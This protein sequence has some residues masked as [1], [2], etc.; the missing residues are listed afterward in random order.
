MMRYRVNPNINVIKSLPILIGIVD[1][2]HS[3]NE[4]KIIKKKLIEILSAPQQN[5]CWPKDEIDSLFIGPSGGDWADEK[6]GRGY[7]VIKPVFSLIKDL[8]FKDNSKCPEFDGPE[9]F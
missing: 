5:R 3:D 7:G 1:S 2:L 8:M 6:D 9:N 4:V